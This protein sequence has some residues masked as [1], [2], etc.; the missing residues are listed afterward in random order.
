MVTLSDNALTVLRSRY[1]KRDNEGKL[2]ETPEELFHR[3]AKAIAGVEK[4]NQSARHWEKRFFEALSSLDFL[5]NSPTLMNAGT[6]LG[7]LSACFVLPVEDSLDSIFSTLKNTALIH[8]SGGGTGFNFSKLRPQGDYIKTTSGESSGPVSFMKIYDAATGQI[9][10]GGKRR[11]ANMGILNIDHPDIEEFITCKLDTIVLN[12]FNISVGMSDAFM[13]AAINDADWELKH[14]RTKKTVKKLK[15]KKLWQQII[16]NAWKTGDPGLIFLDKI[17]ESNPTPKLGTIDATNPCGEVPL[18]PYEPCN[19]GSINLSRMLKE[20]KEVTVDWEKLE[21][22]IETAIRFLDNVIDANNYIIPEI[23]QM[24]KG[25][26][27]IGLGVMGWAEMLIKLKVPYNS[28]EA[29]ELAENLMHFIN[30]KSLEMSQALAEEKGSFPNWEQ[31]IYHPDTPVRNATRTSVAPT[32]TIAIIADTSPSIEPLFALA[33]K[34][35]NV[36][37]EQTLEEV[38]KLLIECLKDRQLYSDHLM[39]KIIESG[40]INE[41]DEIPED[42]K[43]LFPTSLD[44]P[45]HYHIKHQLVFQEYT[46]NAISKTINL[47]EKA[48]LEDVENAYL[49]AWKGGAKGITI[50]RYGSKGKQVLS[51]L[52]KHFI[53]PCKVC[54]E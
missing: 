1:L 28:T 26:R 44:I 31:S 23:E 32:G 10:Q 16:E 50:F 43:E 46:D 40:G 2:C 9:K 4:N 51:K 33:F 39:D 36:L 14:P 37:K 19:L 42:V 54:V 45:Y 53:E 24:A 38:N 29:L 35:E 8:Q 18:L 25:N 48:T 6:P 20:E 5:P 52:D 11:G 13:K 21:H 41:L 30:E 34:R 47:P 15:A 22:T 7:Q 3:V 12:N 49:L 27:K 17:Q